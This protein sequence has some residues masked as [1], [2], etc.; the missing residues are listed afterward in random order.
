[1]PPDKKPAAEIHSMLSEHRVF[2]PP[3]ELSARAHVKSLDE[4]RRLAEE[5]RRDPEAFWAARAR[6][7]IF[8]KEPFHTVLEWKPPFARWFIEGRTN[9]SYNCLDRHLEARADKP[10]L[11]WEGEPGDR[12]SITYRELHAEVCRL[13][14]GLRS[15]G[16]RKGDRVG[17]Y[18]PMVP[19][20]AVAIPPEAEE[21][22]H[23]AELAVVDL[24]VQQVL[25]EHQASLAFHGPQPLR[26]FSPG[27]GKDDADRPPRYLSLEIME[28]LDALPPRSLDQEKNCPPAI[29]RMV[30]S[31]RP[32][33]RRRR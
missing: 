5:A 27:P 15:L 12:R 11:L 7:E 6:E 9:L 30:I 20:A 23:E 1:V 29:D 33:L 25:R 26:A 24:W 4:Y 16:V 17:I 19:E 10:A 14:N 18:L 3:E 13:A 28:G 32:S 8:W 21:V 31:R 2:H 22:H